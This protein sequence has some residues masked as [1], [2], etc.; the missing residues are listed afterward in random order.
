MTT[1]DQSVIIDKSKSKKDGVYSYRG[2]IYAVKDNHFVAFS[3]YYGCVYQCFG[4]FNVQIGTVK[5]YD[6]IRTLKNLLKQII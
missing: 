6:R 5:S 1:D 4:M 2:I 3:D